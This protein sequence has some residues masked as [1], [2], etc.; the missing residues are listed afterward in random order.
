MAQQMQVQQAQISPEAFQ[1]AGTYQLG[2]P[3]AD[4]KAALTRKSYVLMV[5]LLIM[6]V[7]FGFIAFQDNS[8]TTDSGSMVILLIVA[9]CA[10]AGFLWTALYPIIFRSWHVYVCTEGF[11]FTRGSKVDACQWNQIESMWQQVTRRYVNG[12]YTGTDHRYT[13]R[14]NDGF[15]MVFNDRFSKVETLGNTISQEVTRRL[16]P[17]VIEAYNAGNTVTFGPLSVSK[18]GVS[19]GKELLSWN[20]IKGIGVNRGI[21]TVK[22]EGKLLNWSSV[23]VAKVPNIFL[24]MALVNSIISGRQ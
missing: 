6:A 7:L 21:V 18:Q 22:K 13:V 1:L 24:F 19:N 14:R 9:L 20:Q 3:T 2:T 12:V 11:V 10:F 15:E 23:Q 16:F 4:Y 5:V 8:G 17:R